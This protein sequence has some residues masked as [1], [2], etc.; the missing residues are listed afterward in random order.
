M[1]GNISR[2]HVVIHKEN[3]DLYN[4]VPGAEDR[5]GLEVHVAI[6]VAQ[7]LASILSTQI[8]LLSCL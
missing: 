6:C 3:Y 8:E 2:C 7:I 1:Q 5:E 4:T